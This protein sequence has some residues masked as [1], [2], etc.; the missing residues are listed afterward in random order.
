MLSQLS[1]FIHGRRMKTFRWLLSK[2]R[3]T[4]SVNTSIASRFHTIVVAAFKLLA[5]SKYKSF[6]GFLTA[7]SIAS[8]YVHK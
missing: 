6:P 8:I 7:E 1:K 4:S 5:S 2:F 3:T